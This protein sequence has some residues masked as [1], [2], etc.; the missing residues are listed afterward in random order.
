MDDSSHA[1]CQSIQYYIQVLLGPLRG[2]KTHPCTV[3]KEPLSGTPGLLT[4]L[5]TTISRFVVGELQPHSVYPLT[6]WFYV[7]QNGTRIFLQE[8]LIWDLSTSPCLFVTQREQAAH[9]NHKHKIT[10]VPKKLKMKFNFIESTN[11]LS[12]LALKLLPT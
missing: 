2:Q 10:R 3:R 4:N 6:R 9:L 12:I 5:P 11:L 7:G 8:G 1:H